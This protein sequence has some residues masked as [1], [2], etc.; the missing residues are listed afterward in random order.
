VLAALI[1]ILTVVEVEEIEISLL[2]E[3][4]PIVFD[5]IVWVPV[6]ATLSWIPL[7][8]PFLHVIALIV[9]EEIEIWAAAAL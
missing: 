5:D 8:Y 3:D 1:P 4:E 2:T 9:L 7:K 6:A